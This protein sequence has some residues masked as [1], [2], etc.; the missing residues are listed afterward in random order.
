MR[1]IVERLL[2]GLLFI[3]KAALIVSVVLISVPLVDTLCHMGLHFCP[4]TFS[5]FDPSRIIP[6]VYGV[7][8]EEMYQEADGKSTTEQCRVKCFL[9]Q[10]EVAPF[11]PFPLEDV[12][13]ATAGNGYNT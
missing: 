6:V 9:L 12:Q 11:F 10:T 7:P 5:F 8:T 13:S 1:G 3:L 4:P 2:G